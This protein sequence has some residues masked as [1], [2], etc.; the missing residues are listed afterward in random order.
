MKR[1]AILIL[2]WSSSFASAH[3]IRAAYFEI[4]KKSDSYSLLVRFDRD[5]ILRELGAFGDLNQAF[6]QYISGHLSLLF[7]GEQVDW[8][9]NEVQIQDLFILVECEIPY[10]SE[11]KTIN[12]WNTSLIDSIEG[13][14]NVMVLKLHEKNRSFRLNKKRQKTVI[15]Y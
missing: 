14:D 3:D 4:S 15:R 6:A 12:V 7:D 11:V 8:V 5:D 9:V 2:F 1:V 10:D 13:H